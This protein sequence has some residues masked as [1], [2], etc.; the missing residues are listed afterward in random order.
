MKVSRWTASSIVCAVLLVVSLY[1]CYFFIRMPLTQSSNARALRYI[2]RAEYGYTAQVKPSLLY[3]NRTEIGESEPLY[4]KLVERL[5]ITFSYDLDEEPCT[6]EMTNAT[7]E[8]G[9]SASLSSGDWE[10]TYNLA[11]MKKEAPAFT[12]AYTLNMTEIEGIVDTI[13]E[14][15]G[16]RAHSY[17]YEIK[18]RIHLEASAGNKTID[19]DFT[20]TLT[21]KFEGGQIEFEGLK[22]T[23]LD[24]VIQQGNET[25]T[26]M[27]LGS[28]VDV[29]DMRAL[30]FIASIPLAFLLYKSMGHVLRERA[31]R[32]FIECLSN[33]IRDRI[34][35]AQEPPEHIERSTM[36]VGSME[37]LARVAEEAFKPIIHHGDV[38]YVLDG[39][40]RYEFSVVDVDVEEE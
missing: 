34:V 16:I 25:A 35:E 33:D 14:E 5:D 26:Y 8:Y 15:T 9:V 24:S 22:D 7:L 3:D 20:P 19:Q 38:F 18:P 30:S 31:S 1:G 23:K 4:T 6:V 2:Q 36:R 27:I 28:F 37:D 17:I 40:M 32:S 29:S 13:G 10:K 21:I 12:D 11:S 39:D